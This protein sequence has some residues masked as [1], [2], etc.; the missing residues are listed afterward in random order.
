MKVVTAAT[1]CL[2]HPRKTQDLPTEDRARH[3]C[4]ENDVN[5]LAITRAP[6]LGICAI[7]E[8]VESAGLRGGR[9]VQLLLLLAQHGCHGC[10]LELFSSNEK[11][12][13]CMLLLLLQTID[14]GAT[15]RSQAVHAES[16][17]V[18]RVERGTGVARGHTALRGMTTFAGTHNEDPTC[19]RSST[20]ARLLRLGNEVHSKKPRLKRK[21]PT[22]EYGHLTDLVNRKQSPKQNVY[23]YKYPIKFD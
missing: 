7:A 16:Q 17:L 2:K 21:K 14:R 19:A 18:E 6:S 1:T 23:K 10:E 12:C 11:L 8:P 22:V 20:L 4:L 9:G 3:E 15:T 13:E 5:L